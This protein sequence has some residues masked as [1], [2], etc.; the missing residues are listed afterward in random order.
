MSL[1][2]EL[3]THIPFNWDSRIN[4]FGTMKL[5]LVFKIHTS[6]IRD[7]PLTTFKAML[8]PHKC[9]RIVSIY[10]ACSFSNTKKWNLYL[11]NN[12]KQYNFFNKSCLQN[13]YQF[14]KWNII[15][16][17]WFRLWWNSVT[18]AINSLEIDHAIIKYE[19]INSNIILKH[20]VIKHAWIL[21]AFK[22]VLMKI[23]L[24]FNIEIRMYQNSVQHSEL[25]TSWI[26]LSWNVNV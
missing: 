5:S 11:F 23:Y 21:L 9:E 18:R 13:W 12:K 3:T 24:Y 4:L 2:T 1:Y 7:S 26:A 16:V 17:Y 8:E 14:K 20:T 22:H 25:I 15:L 19:E 6:D 10:N